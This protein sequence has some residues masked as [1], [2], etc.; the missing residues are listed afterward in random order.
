MGFY[1]MNDQGQQ[2]SCFIM[3]R[4][5]DPTKRAWY[6]ST[7]FQTG[8]YRAHIFTLNDDYQ[9]VTDSVRSATP[10]RHLITSKNAHKI[11]IN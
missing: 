8:F 4:I 5:F 3:E 7:V 2:L 6:K 9:I 10:R 11:F 1:S